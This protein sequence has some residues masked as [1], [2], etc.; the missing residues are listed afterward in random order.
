MKAFRAGGTVLSCERPPGHRQVLAP[1]EV[2]QPGGEEVLDPPQVLLVGGLGADRQQAGLGAHGPLAPVQGDGGLGLAAFHA[3][4]LGWAVAAATGGPAVTQA[5]AGL[6]HLR[7]VAAEPGQV[8]GGMV[9]RDVGFGGWHGVFLPVMRRGARS[10][11]TRRPGRRPRTGRTRRTRPTDRA[12]ALRGGR[13]RR[14]PRRSSAGSGRWRPAMT[15]AAA[16]P[17]GWARTAR[18]TG[19]R[20]RP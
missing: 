18:R 9:G 6:A 15:T 4:D 11:R 10:G 1:A 19:P 5:V 3:A 8:T 13:C 16:Q 2:L 12:C 20:P 7:G 17:G 14:R